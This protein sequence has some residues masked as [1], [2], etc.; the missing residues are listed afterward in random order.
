MNTA[1]TTLRSGSRIDPL[2]ISFPV[3]I[4]IGWIVALLIAPEMGPLAYAAPFLGALMCLALW[5][6]YRSR[7][8]RR[9]TTIILLV[10]ATSVLS[11]A[12]RQRELG[13]TGLDWQNGAKLAVWCAIIG[14]GAL[15][16]RD[17]IGFLRKP[18]TGLSFAFAAMALLS[19]TW[20]EVPA[21]T[22]ASAFGLVAYLILACLAVR[23][24]D[25]AT[26]IKT[27]LASLTIYLMARA[28]CRPHR[29]RRRVARAICRRD[30]QPA[31]RSVRSPQ[32]LWPAGCD[33]PHLDGD[34]LS[35]GHCSQK[36]R[37]HSPG[38]RVG[39]HSG[40]R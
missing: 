40:K 22:A 32:H 24:L 36:H 13:E 39:G 35:A 12:F 10:V 38:D 4:T 1:A 19:A 18:L 17:L 33:L 11:L 7:D 16:W 9:L 34:F 20:S 6:L 3:A 2:S 14:M 5:C 23:D 37:R 8:R 31:S 29:T 21:Y 26:A 15:R 30:V 25:Q 27:I 28:S